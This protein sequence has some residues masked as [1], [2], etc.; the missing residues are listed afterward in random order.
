MAAVP[1]ETVVRRIR[2]TKTYQND[3]SFRGAYSEQ[4]ILNTRTRES[5][6]LA[7]QAP[8]P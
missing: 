3:R 5:T 8:I 1:M 7:L 6:V 2:I 4:R